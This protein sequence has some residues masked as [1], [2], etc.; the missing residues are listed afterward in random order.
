[1]EI[2]NKPQHQNE[3]YLKHQF[4]KLEIP[5]T[6]IAKNNVVSGGIIYYWFK[7]FGIKG[8]DREK[9][10]H[11]E[12]WLYHQY[13]E[14]K[15]PVKKI[16]VECRA[17]ESTISKYLRKFNIKIRSRRE[18]MLLVL[19]KK[20]GT[21]IKNIKKIKIQYRNYKNNRINCEMNIRIYGV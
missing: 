14:L 13:I 3:D 2:K 5:V 9:L 1:M 8:K 10:Y 6:T 17:N 18:A 20:N 19:S 11:N 15:K 21:N 12:K 4:L 7:K 16:S